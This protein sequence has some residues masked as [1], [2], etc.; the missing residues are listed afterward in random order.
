MISLSFE[1]IVNGLFQISAS[2][3]LFVGQ[4]S[5]WLVWVVLMGAPFTTILMFIED[6]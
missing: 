6:V 3:G 4:A 5:E 2:Q 1:D